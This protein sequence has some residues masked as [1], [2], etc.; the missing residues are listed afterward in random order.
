MNGHELLGESLDSEGQDALAATRAIVGEP[1]FWVEFRIER[2]QLQYLNNRQ[3]A[4]S[5]TEFHDW[6]EPGRKRHLIRFW[7]RDEGR[8]SFHA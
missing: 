6:D 2:G 5:R 8:R 7:N 1:R 3:F 4:H